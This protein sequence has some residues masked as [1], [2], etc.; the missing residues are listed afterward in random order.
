MTVIRGRR[1][2]LQYTSPRLWHHVQVL[3][4][5]GH[6][7]RGAQIGETHETGEGRALV[8]VWPHVLRVRH[9][10]V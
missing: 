9:V 1:I 3:H 6:I 2:T 5:R 7:T 4:T 8:L 10:R